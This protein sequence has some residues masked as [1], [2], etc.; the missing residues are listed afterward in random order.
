VKIYDNII[1]DVFNYIY[2]K[3]STN[4]GKD[5]IKT[6]ING[7][8][9][10]L[11]HH[12]NK[13]GILY[14]LFDPIPQSD[15]GISKTFIYTGF[16]KEILPDYKEGR[17]YDPITIKVANILLKYFD[18]IGD[19]VQILSSKTYEADDFVEPL[20]QKLT[21]ENPDTEIALISN[22]ED[23]ARYLTD[24][25][26]LIN[27]N[28]NKPFTQK[29]F[30][31]IYKFEP[32]ACANTLY[33]SIFGDT[34]DNIQ[35]AIFIK[36]AKFSVPIKEIAL[37]LLI[38]VSQEKYTLQEFLNKWKNTRFFDITKKDCKDAFDE[39]FLILNVTDQ[40]VP[41]VDTFLTNISA[42]RCALENKDITPYISWHPLNESFHK[43]IRDS[44]FGINFKNFGNVSQK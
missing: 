43:I 17:T 25:I 29:A 10:D 7:I 5:L 1:V 34:S 16:R 27:D 18:N 8:E 21:K 3:K 35:G 23:W 30:K 42:I 6:I 26:V 33:K 13:D 32:T 37:N 41:I 19:H 14:L 28:W 40:K 12:L 44:I 39:F 15:L 9:D 4:P 11:Q 20:I 38:Q 2:R 22:D 36:K 31:N 24:K